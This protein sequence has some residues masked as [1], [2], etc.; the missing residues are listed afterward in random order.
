MFI[1]RSFSS[2]ER[3]G[4]SGLAI[5]SEKEII[6]TV[7]DGQL[8]RAVA[9]AMA[10]ASAAARAE[11]ELVEPATIVVAPVA[12]VVGLLEAASLAREAS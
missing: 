1:G 5:Q 2:E 10:Q 3:V 4:A 11:S 9:Q 8:A 6:V 7:V 12:H